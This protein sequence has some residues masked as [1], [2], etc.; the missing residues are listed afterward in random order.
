MSEKNIEVSV[1]V[2][3]ELEPVD[4][5]KLYKF[6][7]HIYSP[8]GN[9]RQTIPRSI[10]VDMCAKHG[11]VIHAMS[12]VKWMTLDE[13]CDSTWRIEKKMLHPSNRSRKSIETALQEMLDRDIVIKKK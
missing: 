5:L 4:S 11:D 1:T 8:N 3:P 7:L 13:I 12:S 2:E 9:V 6:K 10:Y